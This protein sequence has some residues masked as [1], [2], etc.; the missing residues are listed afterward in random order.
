MGGQLWPDLPRRDVP[1]LVGSWPVV[2]VLTLMPGRQSR[3]GHDLANSAPHGANDRC[4]AFFLDAST[5]RSPSKEVPV[6]GRDLFTECDAVVTHT[7]RPSWKYHPRRTRA[8]SREQRDHDNVVGHAVP[9][10]L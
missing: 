7:P 9:D 4:H 2:F 1:D 6:N 5:E 3:F 10:I 8:T